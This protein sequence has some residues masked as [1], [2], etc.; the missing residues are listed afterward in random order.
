MKDEKV[1]EDQKPNDE[2]PNADLE[3]LVGGSL[4]NTVFQM[5]SDSQKMISDTQKSV[6]ANIRA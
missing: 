5:I 3:K 1:T 4:L 6:I 2:L